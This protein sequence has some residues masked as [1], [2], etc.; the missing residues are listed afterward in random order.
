MATFSDI[1]YHN[2]IR[3]AKNAARQFAKARRHGLTILKPIQEG[4]NHVSHYSYKCIFRRC[5]QDL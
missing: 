1:D 2:H 5:R 3:V 4:E